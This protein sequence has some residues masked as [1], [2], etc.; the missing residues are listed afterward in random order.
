MRNRRFVELGIA[1]VPIVIKAPIKKK[2][3]KFVSVKNNDVIMENQ[4]VIGVI[5]TVD[6]EFI[7]FSINRDLDRETMKLLRSNI[8]RSEFW[9]K[10]LKFK[11]NGFEIFGTVRATRTDKKINYV[12]FDYIEEFENKM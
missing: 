9:G 5:T 10:E 11:I 8:V 1:E 12:I 3:K 4:K 7:E 6:H 2:D